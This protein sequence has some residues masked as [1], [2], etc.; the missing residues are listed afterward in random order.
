M[1]RLGY[2]SNGKG[3][4]VQSFDVTNSKAYNDDTH[5][6]SKANLL[7]I[8]PSKARA[9]YKLVDDIMSALTP[10]DNETQKSLNLELKDPTTGETWSK[11]QL[12]SLE[13]SNHKN[14]LSGLLH[15]SKQEGLSISKDKENPELIYTNENNWSFI[16][17]FITHVARKVKGLQ[18]SDTASNVED[19]TAKIYRIDEDGKRSVEPIA[20]VSLG[21]WFNDDEDI[22]SAEVS[23]TLLD[24]FGLAFHGTTED[25]H[26][27]NDDGTVKKVGP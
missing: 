24:M 21:N 10:N 15:Y 3:Q 16:S 4:H 18:E 17:G 26:K 2:T 9:Y 23:D 20:T 7:V 12:I 8:L 14:T 13:N 6:T 27:L 25:I 11:D 19:E 1:F 5:R 22:D